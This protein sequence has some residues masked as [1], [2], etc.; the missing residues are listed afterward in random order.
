MSLPC[1]SQKSGRQLAHAGVEQV[2]VLQHLVVEVVL[3]VEAQRARLDAHVDVFGHQDDL[4]LRLLCLQVHHHADDLVVG[5]RGGQRRAAARRR[6]PRSAG[7]AGPS[8]ARAD[9]LGERNA[10]VDACARAPLTMSSSKR[11]AWRALRATSVMP[12]LLLSSS[13]S[14]MI[15]TKMSCSSKRNRLVGS[16][17]STLV[18]RTNSLVWAARLADIGRSNV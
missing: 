15:G 8:P 18:S 3:G 4:A 14:V 6:S 5:L 12:F 16:C 2:G 9:G 13:S 7:T 1:V 17:I 10:V 11:L